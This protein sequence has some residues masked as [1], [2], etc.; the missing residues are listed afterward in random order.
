MLF[1][2]V[3]SPVMYGCILF[4]DTMY[5]LMLL[6]YTTKLKKNRLKMLEKNQVLKILS[7]VQTVF[8]KHVDICLQIRACEHDC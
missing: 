2:F 6:F 4:G 5:I 1:R 7:T 8:V 3:L